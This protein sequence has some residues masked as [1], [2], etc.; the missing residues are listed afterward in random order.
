MIAM[1]NLDLPWKI[2][3]KKDIY[4][5]WATSD[6]GKM[7]QAADVKAEFV[8][9]DK[10]K[11]GYT[12]MDETHEDFVEIV[13]ALLICAEEEMGGYL[14]AFLAHAD[15]HFSQ[16][17]MW[18]KESNFPG[19]QCHID[20]HNAV[21]KSVHE[22][23]QILMLGREPARASALVRSLASELADWFPA[24]ADYLDSALAQWLVKRRLGGI[25][26]VLRRDMDFT[27]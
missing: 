2:I 20:E 27:L 22:V 7:M 3:A 5:A 8:W 13:G 10:F 19:M 6:G 14:D 16:E 26:L 21:L 25:P 9:S 11:L 23:R 17:F 1:I 18:M 24:H 4:P 12:P 15:A